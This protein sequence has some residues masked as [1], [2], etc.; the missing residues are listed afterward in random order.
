MQHSF[1]H[2]VP[3]VRLLIAF[4]LGIGTAMFYAVHIVAALVTT[5]VFLLLALVLP[6]WFCAYQQRW[7]SGI[8]FFGLFYCL[9]II[10][11]IQ[12][13]HLNNTSHF[14]Y[15]PQVN[16]FLVMASWWQK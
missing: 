8:C 12:Q 5:G 6:K 4:L 15:Q 9:G 3:I 2:S 11:N 16:Y 14:S 13:N 7:F 10:L 1:W